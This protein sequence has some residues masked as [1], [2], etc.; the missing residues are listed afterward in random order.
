MRIL[1]MEKGGLRQRQDVE[2]DR[3]LKVPATS[4]TFYEHISSE[5]SSLL[6]RIRVQKPRGNTGYHVIDT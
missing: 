5:N 2:C 3:N 4:V 6:T 1:E